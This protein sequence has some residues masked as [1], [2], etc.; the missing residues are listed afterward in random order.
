M[1]D[2]DEVSSKYPGFGQGC[3]SILP[4]D[5]NRAGLLWRGRGSAVHAVLEE[6]EDIA[7]ISESTSF[8]QG[9]KKGCISAQAKVVKKGRR[10]AFVEGRVT[11]RDDG[12]P[13]SLTQA[14]FA[15][16]PRRS[17]RGR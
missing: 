9:I 2:K 5:G 6:E 8:L 10:V 12:T 11:S 16:I 1:V 14:S 15:I 17:S 13:L 7:T 4:V 3:Q